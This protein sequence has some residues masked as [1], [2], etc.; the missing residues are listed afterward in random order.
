MK[1]P[2][3]YSLFYKNIHVYIYIY[4]VCQFRDMSGGEYWWQTRQLRDMSG[5]GHP[6]VG[7]GHDL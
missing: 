4:R 2:T 5:G 1:S 6:H 7:A 3:K